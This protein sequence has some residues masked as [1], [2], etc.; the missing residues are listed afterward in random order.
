M[1]TGFDLGGSAPNWKPTAA[2]SAGTY[3]Q[4]LATPRGETPYRLAKWK[5]EP[6]SYERPAGMPWSEVFV[7]YRG[8]GRIRFE[9]GQTVQIVPGAVIDLPKGVPYV[10]DIEETLE[11]MAV[12]TLEPKEGP[13]SGGS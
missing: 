10:L 11:K 8:R 2:G 6:G 9:T 3:A 12:I 4:A 5:G 1:S 7:A 13:P